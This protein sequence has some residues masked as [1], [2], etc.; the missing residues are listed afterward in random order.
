MS[1]ANPK[2]ERIYLRVDPGLKAQ[3]TDIFDAMGMTPSEAV[4]LFLLEVIRRGELP[5]KIRTPNA[6]TRAAIQAARSG[7]VQSVRRQSRR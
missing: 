5:M 3:A 7:T 6:E 2:T 1:S 4:R